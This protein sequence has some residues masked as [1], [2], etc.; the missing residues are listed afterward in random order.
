M[1][2]SRITSGESLGYSQPKSTETFEARSDKSWTVVDLE[3]YIKNIAFMTLLDREKSKFHCMSMKV[4]G[5]IK[6][7][8]VKSK[9]A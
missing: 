7:K 4:E 5:S 3:Q 6:I 9:Q 1:P 2:L 8:N